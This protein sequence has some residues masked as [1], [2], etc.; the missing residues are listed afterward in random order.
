VNDRFIP[1]LNKRMEADGHLVSPYG[2]LRNTP[3][4]RREFFIEVFS[5]RYS[6]EYAAAL[7]RPCLLVETH[8]LKTAKTRAWSNYDIMVHSIDIVVENPQALR[9]AVR[10]ADAKYAAMA[11]DRSAPAIYL[12]GKTSADAHPLIYHTLK[13]APLPSEITGT[14]VTRYLPDKDDF[15]TVTHDGIDTAAEAQEPLGF[16]IPLAWRI[17]PTNSRCMA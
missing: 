7:N 12:A 1:E 15:E 10:D 2:A 11:G 5:P 16:L 8:S 6:H 13:T 4:G 14:M 17:S 9:K 3:S